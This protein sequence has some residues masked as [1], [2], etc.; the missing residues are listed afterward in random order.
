[1]AY[2]MSDEEKEAHVMMK[3][4]IDQKPRRLKASD[5]QPG[6]IILYSY[7]AK[8]D[9]NPYDANP[10]VFI[11]GT[12]GR[13]Y[14]YGINFNWIPPVLRKGII[15]MIMKANKK[16]IEKG[17]PLVVPKDLVKKI[18]RMGVPAFRKYLKN[19]ISPKGVVVPH[20]VY[21]KVVNL[22]AEHF[23]NISSEKAWKIA[24][25]RIKRNKKKV[26]RKDKGYR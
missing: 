24:V 21:P 8:F 1:M 16:N 18:F 12:K 4:L 13:K 23:I 25:S 2:K 9:K 5:F 15:G 17:R 26:A 20:E 11:L 10:L 3:N 19:R 7:K 6:Q 22:R 14:V